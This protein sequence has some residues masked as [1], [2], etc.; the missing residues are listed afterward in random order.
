[1]IMKGGETKMKQA[2][3]VGQVF[4]IVNGEIVM[5]DDIDAYEKAMELRTTTF[6]LTIDGVKYTNPICNQTRIMEL[7]SKV[8]DNKEKLVLIDAY[9]KLYNK[10]MGEN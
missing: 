3:K 8:V 6:S 2:T 9:F 5:Y 4:E 10:I 1:M 7:I